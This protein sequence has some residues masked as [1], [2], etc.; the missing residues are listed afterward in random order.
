MWVYITPNVPVM[1]IQYATPFK[2]CF[3]IHDMW[4]PK[5]RSLPVLEKFLVWVKVKLT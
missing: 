2:A 3:I 5:K 4:L 1:E